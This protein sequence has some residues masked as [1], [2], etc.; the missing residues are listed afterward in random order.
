MLTNAGE[1]A[2]EHSVQTGADRADPLRGS[3]CGLRK[4]Q[5]PTL[6]DPHREW[7]FDIAQYLLSNGTTEMVRFVP[8][9]VGGADVRFGRARQRVQRWPLHQFSH[10]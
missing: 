7:L 10:S 2:N 5:V 8:I 9:L 6:G 3:V 1:E 4:R